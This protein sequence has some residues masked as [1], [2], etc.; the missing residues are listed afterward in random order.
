MMHPL[1]GFLLPVARRPVVLVLAIGF[2]SVLGTASLQARDVYFEVEP[3][4]AR[5]E[6]VNLGTTRISEGA[7]Y[8]G[9]ATID[10]RRRSEPYIVEISA[11]GY[12]SQ[13]VSY[14]FG[15]DRGR[16]RYRVELAKLV[17]TKVFALTS[18]PSGAAVY[19]GDR[20][21]GETP[22]RTEIRFSRPTGTAPWSEATLEFRREDYQTES[23]VLGLNSSAEVPA[24]ELP[25]LRLARSIAITAQNPAGEA[26]QATVEIDGEVVGTTP[27]TAE[28]V[29]TRPDDR[30]AWTSFELRSYLENAFEPST[31]MIEVTRRGPVEL[32]LEPVTEVE[33]TR[34]FPTVRNLPSGPERGIDLSAPVGT[35]D[36]R[37]ISFNPVD[38]RVITNFRRDEPILQAIN[39]YCLTPDGQ[40]LIYSVTMQT[41]AGDYYANLFT[42]S[43]NDSSNVIS[44]I[45]RGSRFVDTKPTMSR[46]EESNL[47][48]FQSNRGPFESW[49]ISSLT[50]RGGRVV[51][52]IRQLTRDRNRLNYD[53]SF[54]SEEQPVYFSSAET[55]PQ[56]QPYISLVRPDG[57]SF[58]NLGEFGEQLVRTEGGL[59]YFVRK[60]EDTGKYQIYSITSEGLQFSSVINDVEFGRAN[61]MQPAVSP[62][63]SRLLFVSDYH[64]DEEGRTNNNIYLYNVPTGEI[65]QLT[66][67]GSDD[68]QPQWSPT[69]PGVL[70]FLSNRG[71]VYNVWRMQIHLN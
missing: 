60:A 46:E 1:A 56:A 41:E 34:Y 58:T 52:G 29:F 26:L 4:G 24:V 51:G 36:S 37:D 7:V 67:N 59:I 42:K 69:E 49:D 31:E 57:S 68:V 61:V 18:E 13:R 53:A 62:D 66:D 71:G 20:L 44:Q 6:I 15:A 5:L 21:L 32:V 28:L 27:H 25:R 48:V 35:L 33:V 11:P 64:A 23:I 10:F 55:Y 8:T 2:L 9:P 3:A 12:E 17:E 19:L 40:N 38:F 39:S 50:L 63:G 16:E 47:V 22:T 45:T 14:D 43:A 65:R 70:F 54:V 30:S